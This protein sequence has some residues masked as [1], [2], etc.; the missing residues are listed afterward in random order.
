MDGIDPAVTIN[1]EKMRHDM[2]WE[3]RKFIVATVAAAATLLAA[4]VLLGRWMGGS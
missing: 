4:G 2:R 3:T 1:I